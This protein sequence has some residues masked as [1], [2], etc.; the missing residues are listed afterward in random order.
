LIVA[1]TL[2]SD[3]RHTSSSTEAKNGRHCVVHPDINKT[4]ELFDLRGCALELFSVGNIQ[5][6]DERFAA[7][8]FHIAPC[9]IEPV[10]STGDQTDTSAFARKRARRGAADA[11]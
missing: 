9:A 6:K 10:A 8:C 3:R 7:A 11:P 5:R 2:Q 4:E 1:T